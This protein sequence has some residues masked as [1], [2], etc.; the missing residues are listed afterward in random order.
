MSYI[1]SIII[2]TKNRYATLFSLVDTLLGFDDQEI[3]IIIQDNSDDNTAALLFI[4]DRRTKTALKYFHDPRDLSVIENSDLAVLNSSGEYVCFIGDD[5]GVMPFITDVVRWMK[6]KEYKALK[7][8]KPNYY[9]PNQRSNILSNDISGNLNLKNFD[10]KIRII[11]C[12]EALDY[13]LSKGGT[14][15]KM[16]PC[17]YHGIVARISLNKIY[18]QCNTYFP[19]PSPDM[20]NAIAL[21]Q[22][23]DSHVRVSFPVVIS[24]KSSKSTGGAGVLHQ[25]VARIEDVKYLPKNTSIEWTDTIPKYWTGPTIWAESVIKALNNFGNNQDIKKFNFSY[26]Y[27]FISV[28][29]KKQGQ[30]IYKDFRFTRSGFPYYFNYLKIYL[31]RVFIFINN[32]RSSNKKIFR[33]VKNISEAIKIIAGELKMEKVKSIIR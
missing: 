24:G 5:D 17:L 13:T 31:N 16:L 6:L 26:L 9:W 21:T 18:D 33:N 1:L 10:Y 15:I 11:K 20:A 14:S 3:E 4:A 25:H 8:F 27:A 22:I 7:S 2:P 32:K 19:G 30:Q 28:F 23:M 29:H 12:R